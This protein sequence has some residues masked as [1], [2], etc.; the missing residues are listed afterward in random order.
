MKVAKDWLQQLLGRL[1]QPISRNQALQIAAQALADPSDVEFLVCQD[2]T[3]SM[4]GG[5]YRTTSEPCWY[6]SAPWDDHKRV[7]ALRSS[8]VILVGKLTGMIHFDGSANDEG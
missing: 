6:I 1:F 7:W 5:L 2:M 3:P 8:R 4:L